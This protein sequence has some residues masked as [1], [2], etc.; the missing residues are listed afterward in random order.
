MGR[1]DATMSSDGRYRRTFSV[2]HRLSIEDL[3]AVIMRVRELETG[4]QPS[5]GDLNGR[6]THMLWVYGHFL[7]EMDDDSEDPDERWEWAIQLA[8]DRY[9]KYFRTPD[10]QGVDELHF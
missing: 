4:A 1:G 9:E 10:R 8:K 5:Y 2:R 3:A 7:F 6:I